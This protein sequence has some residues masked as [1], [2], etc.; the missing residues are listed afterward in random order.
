MQEKL[1]SIQARVMEQLE[2]ATD[3][4]A[5]EQIRVT[6]LGKKGELT[7]ILRSMGQLPPEERPIMGQ[8]VNELRAQI[9]EKMA[10]REAVLREREKAV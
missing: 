10:E 3:T 4:A 2:Q 7:G 5:L 6:V 8:K 9:E 1:Q